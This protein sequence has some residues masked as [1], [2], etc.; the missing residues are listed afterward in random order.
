V[1][2]V[3][4]LGTAVALASLAF[5]LLQGYRYAGDLRTLHVG[6][7]S[8]A[9]ALLTL[10][11]M[12][13]GTV[14][15]A[16]AWR[17]LLVAGG[18]RI[19]FSTAY[20]I[21]ARSAIAKYLP[22]NVFQ[23]LS[24]VALGRAYG[25][26]VEAIVVSTAAETVFVVGGAL[27][28]GSWSLARLAVVGPPAWVRPAAATAVLAVLILLGV[29]RWRRAIR[30]W[31]AAHAGYLS[32]GR[33]GFVAL[34]AVVE[35]GAV[36]ASLAVLR[37]AL[38]PEAPHVGWFPFASAFAAAWTAGFVVPGA[39]GGIGVREFVLYAL[40]GDRLGSGPA[41]QLFLLARL[42]ST[43]ADGLAF[44]LSYLAPQRQPAEAIQAP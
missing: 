19:P 43:C 32:P 10:S 6:A 25:V 38:W 9:A 40:L 24:R 18:V 11:V 8:V 14:V 16:A 41:A 2:F 23:Y 30:P 3:R 33:A 4:H 37:A 26:P 31:L 5:L 1:R 13:T 20:V 44:A 12:T 39:P 42:L 17:N 28:L 22:G 27:L 36:G 29:P 34:A 35:L 7:T 21:Q 15:T